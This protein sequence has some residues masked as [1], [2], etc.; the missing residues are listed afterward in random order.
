MIVARRYYGEWAMR[1][2]RLGLQLWPIYF[3]DDESD[4]EEEEGAAK[5]ADP[6]LRRVRIDAMAA[7]LSAYEK[8][9][10]ANIISNQRRLKELFGTKD[11]A[12][13]L[14]PRRTQHVVRRAP[15]SSAPRSA[16]SHNSGATCVFLFLL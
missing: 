7:E 8:Q 6:P 9:R 5:V 4:D 3:P 12:S 11:A 15:S 1:T 13:V 10:N 14:V 16:P 2:H